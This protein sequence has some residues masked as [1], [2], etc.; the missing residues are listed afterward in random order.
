MCCLFGLIDY[1]HRLSGRQKTRIVSALAMESE[2]RG[3]DAAGIAYNTGGKLQ[4]YKR[5]G[6]AH[7]LSIYLP[8]DAYA[9]TGHTR[10]AT[11]GNAKRNRNN[12]PFLGRAGSTRFALAHNGVLHNDKALRR[13]EHLPKTEI[14]TDSYVAVQLLKKKRALSPASLKYMAEQVEGSFVFTILDQQNTVYF[15]KGDNPL[16]LLHFPWLGLYLYASTEAI[17]RRAIELSWLK[18]ECSVKVPVEEGDILTIDQR[19]NNQT[20]RFHLCEAWTASWEQRWFDSCSSS[21]A[22][23]TEQWYIQQLKSA[24]SAF[25]YAPEQIDALLM[26]GWSTDEIEDAI[27]CCEEL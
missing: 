21:T 8:Q 4:I 24:A 22:C 25:G 23:G 15:V 13:S 17:L 9:I 12:H 27:Y 7:K 1:K 5:P 2:A 10:L 6:P 11:Q 3:T 18:Y 19:G 14:E 16:C 20:E 26:E